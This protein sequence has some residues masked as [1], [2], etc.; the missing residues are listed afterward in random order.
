MPFAHTDRLAGMTGST[1][2][3]PC[4]SPWPGG[5]C[6]DFRLADT[7]RGPNQRDRRRDGARWKRETRQKAKCQSSAFPQSLTVAIP[8]K[9]DSWLCFCQE[10]QGA[11]R[12]RKQDPRAFCCAAFPLLSLSHPTG[13]AQS[14]PN[15]SQCTDHPA[16][17]AGSL[18]PA[19]AKRVP[20]RA[21]DGRL[22]MAAARCGDDSTSVPGRPTRNASL[23]P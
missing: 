13:W 19:P 9:L 11:I 6:G 16:R 23:R 21:T 5:Q 2:T 15:C 4:L 14:T 7:N 12:S 8:G 3:M 18:L 1:C 20:F 10:M 17:P 22:C